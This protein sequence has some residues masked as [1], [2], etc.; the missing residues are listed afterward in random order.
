MFYPYA[1]R[2]NLFEKHWASVFARHVSK[3]HPFSYT[4]NWVNLWVGWNVISFNRGFCNLFH[5]F[6]SNSFPPDW[7]KW[8]LGPAVKFFGSTELESFDFY[9]HS[10]SRFLCHYYFISSEVIGKYCMKVL[11]FCNRTYDKTFGDLECSPIRQGTNTLFMFQFRWGLLCLLY[12][13]YGVGYMR[14]FRLR[15]GRA[16]RGTLSQSLK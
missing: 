16:L 13:H 1:I 11:F 12:S 3:S 2:I 8:S 7:G 6:R 14:W 10:G 5:L 9:L 4:I 15:S